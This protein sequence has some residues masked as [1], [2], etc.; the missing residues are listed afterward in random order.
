MA[1]AIA[2]LYGLIFDGKDTIVKLGLQKDVA[3]VSAQ[4]RETFDLFL[5]F[6]RRILRI[7]MSKWMCI[8]GS[9]TSRMHIRFEQ[10]KVVTLPSRIYDHRSIL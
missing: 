10:P 2:H 6:H 7:G 8:A 3:L 5:Y 9:K 4:T 1:L